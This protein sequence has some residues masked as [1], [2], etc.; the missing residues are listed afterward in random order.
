MA[1]LDLSLLTLLGLK[2]AC[3]L[4]ID[5]NNKVAFIK[6]VDTHTIQKSF[7]TKIKIEARYSEAMLDSIAS[8]II[9]LTAVL[10]LIISATNE[11]F[12]KYYNNKL[13]FYGFK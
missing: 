5:K 1:W 7:N 4:Y 9:I 6:Y 12:K 8:T 11:H 3:F 13:R 2:T 10:T